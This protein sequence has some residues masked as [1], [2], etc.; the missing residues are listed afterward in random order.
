MQSTL[1]N[2]GG[3]KW[4]KLTELGQFAIEDQELIRKFR[5]YASDNDLSESEALKEAIETWVE[6]RS[7]VRPGHAVTTAEREK[8]NLAVARVVDRLYPKYQKRL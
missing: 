8:I 5:R 2:A 4:K 1:P 3:E 6:M 7:Q